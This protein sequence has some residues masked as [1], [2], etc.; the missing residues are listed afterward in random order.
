M[1]RD[2]KRNVCMNYGDEVNSVVRQIKEAY[3]MFDYH[4]VKELLST[5]LSESE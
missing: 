5:L 2:D 3:D 1:R 4:K